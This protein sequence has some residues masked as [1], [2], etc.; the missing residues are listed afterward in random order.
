MTK[1]KV[2]FVTEHTGLNTGYAVYA[3][4]III[5]LI[6][7][8]VEVAEF[9]MGINQGFN[10]INGPSW[11]VF[12]NI[13]DD[14]NLR[15]KYDSTQGSEYGGWCF[16]SVLLA[17]KPTHVIDIRDNWHFEY[18]LRSPLRKYF[19]HIAM[20]PVDAEPQHKQWLDLYEQSDA[21]LGYTQW[22]MDL[23]KAANPNINVVGI[24]PPFANAE[25]IPLQN[26]EDLKKQLGFGNINIVGM[27][28]RNQKRKLFPDLFK[29]F[30]MFLDSSGR[31]DVFL[32]CHTA[33]PERGWDI[34]EEV[35]SN[36]IQNKTL[37]TYICKN[38]RNI[39]I[40]LLQGPLTTCYHCRNRTK[41]LANSEFGL[42]H[43]QMSV[44]YNVMDL[45]VQWASCEGYAL[46]I[47]EATA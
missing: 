11:Q 19:A 31:N 10:I 28:G 22:G 23:I 33:F 35:M 24:T 2:L 6:E 37:F 42:N 27:V 1:N 8:G 25:Y 20:T 46:P 30:K 45:Y 4:N 21:I 32:Y 38:C 26:R 7:A 39:E 36:G 5:G 15:A 47:M 34:E 18:Q 29:S 3:R 14:P 12:P 16:E 9:A 44:V 41:I 43:Q 13:P 17:Y 40:G